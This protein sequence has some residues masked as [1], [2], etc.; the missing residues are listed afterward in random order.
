MRA[1][2]PAL[3]AR[4]TLWL[5][6]SGAALFLVVVAVSLGAASFRAGADAGR[7]DAAPRAADVTVEP[8]A[9]PREAS[10]GPALESARNEIAADDEPDDERFLGVVLADESVD[11]LAAVDG[12]VLE[13][14]V[15]PG[16]RVEAGQPLAVLDSESL[17]HRLTEARASLALIMAEVYSFEAQMGQTQRQLERRRSVAGLYS[18]EELESSEILFETSRYR[19]DVAKAEEIQGTARVR[20]LERQVSQAVVR[21]PFDGSIA[22]RFVDPGTLANRGTPLLR[23]VSPQASRLR[24]AVPPDR[25]DRLAIGA[26]LRL[27]VASLGRNARAVLER[28]APEIDAASEMV[29]FEARLEAPASGSGPALP[30]GAVARVTVEAPTD[31]S[32]GFLRLQSIL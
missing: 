15:R 12:R 14:R 27:E 10:G 1:M 29:F 5:A 9:P 28:R 31:E 4:R 30:P 20:E 32:K 24:F 3:P 13:M 19:F 2:R 26:S 21:A 8:A 22:L 23:L 18:R 7:E 6:L 17:E 25:A 16:D 11:L